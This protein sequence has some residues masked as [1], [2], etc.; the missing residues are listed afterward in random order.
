[1]KGFPKVDL[2]SELLELEL[3][4]VV[5]EAAV[6]VAAKVLKRR[7]S[8]SQTDSELAQLNVSELGD[9]EMES[10][11]KPGFTKVLVKHSSSLVE[12]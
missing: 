5:G 2:H 1:M 7:D 10:T 4:A 8:D 6:A 9:Q 11:F 3:A 12:A